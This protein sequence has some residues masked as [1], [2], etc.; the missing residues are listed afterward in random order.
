MSDR[1][2]ES[3]NDALTGEPEQGER[4]NFLVSLG[5]WSKA[6]VGGVVLGGMLAPHRDAKAWG[7]ANRGGGNG[8]WVNFGGGG[9]GWGWGRPWGWYNR[10]GWY[11]RGWY[12]RAHGPGWY[13]RGGWY[14]RP[15][16]PGWYNGTGWGG[17][18]GNR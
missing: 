15:Y 6:V 17:G 11:N 18:W 9:W 2:H 5:K 16:G 13:N 10:P 7:W 1:K 12:N 8:S 4:R 3:L 14:N